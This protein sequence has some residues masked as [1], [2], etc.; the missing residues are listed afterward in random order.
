MT[1]A[2]FFFIAL[3]VLAVLL[4]AGVG[5]AALFGLAED[6]RGPGPHRDDE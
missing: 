6:P 5:V 1:L 4:F 2:S 3:I